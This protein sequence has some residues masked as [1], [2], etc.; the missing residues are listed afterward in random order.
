MRTIM[1][2]ALTLCFGML[3]G[4]VTISSQENQPPNRPDL[5]FPEKDATIAV[6]RERF[7]VR[8]VDPEGDQVKFKIVVMETQPPPPPPMGR[9]RQSRIWVFDQTQDQ[10]GWDKEVYDSGEIATFTVPEN[11]RIPEGEYLWWALVTDNN[12]QRW[13]LIS[14]R[15]KVKFVPN[16]TPS[17]PQLLAPPESEV[18]SPTPTFK[19]K[20]EDPDGDNVKFEIEVV[21]GNEK[22]NFVTEFVSSGEEATFTVPSEQSLSSGQWSW[23]AKAIDTEGMESQWSEVRNFIVNQPPSIPFLLSPSE[24]E[25]VSPT[26]TFK[27]KAED[28]DEDNVKFEIEVVKDSERK[29]FTTDF[30]ASGSEAVFT[31]P[32]EQALSSGQWSWK[33]RAI[34]SNGG[35]SDWSASLTFTVQQTNQPPLTPTLLSPSDGATVSPTPTF[36][37]KSDDPDGDQ[38]KFEIEVMKESERKT[39]TTDFVASGSEAVFTVPSEQALSSGQWSWRARAI[40]T[41]GMESQ[42][43][44]VRNFIVNQPPSIPFLL[45]PSEGEKVSPTPTF[46]LKA[47]DPDEDNV[48]FEIEVVKDSERKTFTTDFVAS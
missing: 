47:E 25:T 9:G 20:A 41:E 23:R 10:T 46:K 45:S 12:G 44:E 36:K 17:I 6:H 33:A 32:S 5:V 42:W 3:F 31:V 15:R 13:S 35:V 11:Q 37:L 7:Q 39:F 34:D 30:V 1:S 40:D 16:R 4:I 28:P 43:S 38:V 48:K 27:L 26:P 19:L 18:V 14:E 24:G 8:V 2:I 22:K 29:T 21:K